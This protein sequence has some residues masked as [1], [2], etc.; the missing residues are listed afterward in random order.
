VAGPQARPRR[1]LDAIDFAILGLLQDDAR[2]PLAT[3]ARR[4]GLSAPGLQKRLRRL[5]QERVILRYAALVDR[6]AVDIDLLCFVQVTLARHQPEAVAGFRKAI[7]AMSEVL[8][9]HHVTGDFDYLLKVV[10]PHHRALESF[11]VD[12][13]TPVRGI[14]RIRTGIVLSEVK[15]STALPLSGGR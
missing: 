13:L 7:A 8:E 1:A 2:L 12:K 15:V 11:L 5:E 3:L 6:A 14:D 4:V 9:C 10:V